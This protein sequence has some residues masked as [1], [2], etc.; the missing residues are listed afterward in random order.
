M[1]E[2]PVTSRLSRA[3]ELLRAGDRGPELEALIEQEVIDALNSRLGPRD[4]DLVGHLNGP[5]GAP[6]I[7]C[8][9]REIEPARFVIELAADGEAADVRLELRGGKVPDVLAHVPIAIRYSAD[10][11]PTDH[12]WWSDTGGLLMVGELVHQDA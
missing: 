6:Q 8:D 5:D 4:L 12:H 1:G 10:A 7:I 3:L 11:L 2:N 9:G